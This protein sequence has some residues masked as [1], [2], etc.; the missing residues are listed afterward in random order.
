MYKGQSYEIYID[1]LFMT[2]FIMDLISLWI[3]KLILKRNRKLRYLI[4]ASIFGT[5]CNIALFL[6]LHNYILYQICIH[7]LIN[8]LTVMIAYGSRKPKKICMEYVCVYI[9]IIFLGGALDFAF[10]QLGEMKGYWIFVGIIVCLIFGGLKLW[11]QMRPVREQ[12]YEVVL[13]HQGVKSVLSGFHDT[14]NL[15][16]DPFVNRPV[17]I[18]EK[19]HIEPLIKQYD[20]NV[21]YIPYHSLGKENGLLPVVTLDYMYINREK[22]PVCIQ[23]PVCGIAKDKLFQ[24]NMCQILLNAQIDINCS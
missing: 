7:F 12:T 18:I 24:N 10:I 15:L 2:N 8:P 17:H 14:G 6:I 9:G 20:I 5:T 21:R 13:L 11:E 3:A 4:C 1:T 16:V 23:K 22:D 19:E